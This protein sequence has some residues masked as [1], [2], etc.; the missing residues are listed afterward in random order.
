[1]KP[2]SPRLVAIVVLVLAAVYLAVLVPPAARTYVSDDSVFLIPI[3]ASDLEG[4]S[5][6]GAVSSLVAPDRAYLP[7]AVWRLYALASLGLFGPSNAGLVY[8]ALLLH[9]ASSCLVWTLAR[10]V[11]MGGRAAWL[12]AGFHLTAWAG[13]H[14]ALW[15]IAVQHAI[16]SL[17]VLAV[18]NLYLAAE[19]HRRAGRPW[20]ALYWA[21]VA[22]ALLSSL[23]RVTS[24]IGPAAILVHALLHPGDARERLRRYDFWWPVVLLSAC[25][26]LALLIWGT[27]VEAFGALPWVANFVIRASALGMG[28]LPAL[29]GALAYVAILLILGRAVLGLWAR[30]SLSSRVRLPARWVRTLWTVGIAAAAVWLVRVAIVFVWGLEAFLWPLGMALNSHSAFRWHMTALP[31]DAVGIALA[32]AVAVAFLSRHGRNWDLLPLGV[33]LLGFGYTVYSWDARPLRYWIYITPVLAIVLAAA[34]DA[35]ASW[36]AGDGPRRGRWQD[37]ALVAAGAIVILSNV[38]AIRLELWRHKAADAYLA[39]DYVRAADLI[40]LDLVRAGAPR[41]APICVDGLE[42]PPTTHEWWTHVS[43]RAPFREYNVRST[44]A[45]ALGRRD[46]SAFRLDCGAGVPAGTYAYVVRDTLVLRDGTP[47]DPFAILHARL[48]DRIGAQDYPG[49]LALAGDRAAARPFLVRFLLEERLADDDVLWATNGASALSWLDRVAA[50]HDS[51]YWRPDV[52]TAALRRLAREEIAAYVR[53][54]F[55][56]QY[57]HWRVPAPGPGWEATGRRLPFGG[58]PLSEIE[59]I[60]RGDPFFSSQPEMRTLLD[61]IVALSPEPEGGRALGQPRSLTTL[62]FFAFLGRLIL[63]DF[64]L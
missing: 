23:S 41:N 31:L 34:M 45:Q 11:G 33:M 7:R 32:A 46:V 62:P 36:M 57:A 58:I 27:A 56:V 38:A 16:S 12:A 13:F 3:V 29:A 55:L 39:L 17:G 2:S 10:R 54:L 9:M 20:R 49:A 26:P 63:N 18:L 28:R 40:R 5:F 51:W 44:L 25:Y 59:V 50:N 22:V 60:V 42:P 21:T 53:F 14:A 6:W 30:S 37:A 1:M 19:Q 24:L 15:P 35:A 52:K 48:R 43:R 4:R 61:G 64:G 47:I 8:G